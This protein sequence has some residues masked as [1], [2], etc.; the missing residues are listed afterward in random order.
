MLILTVLRQI[1]YKIQVIFKSMCLKN[2]KLSEKVNFE[3]SKSP[4]LDS[5]RLRRFASQILEKFKIS[6]IH[7]K[8]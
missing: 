5:F 7:F 4:S 1:R 8:R 2:R 3:K 6:R